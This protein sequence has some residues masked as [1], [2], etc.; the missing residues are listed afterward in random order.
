MYT[1]VKKSAPA[2]ME[3]YCKETVRAEMYVTLLFSTVL[4]DATVLVQVVRGECHPMSSDIGDLTDVSRRR[5]TP[6]VEDIVSKVEA[7]YPIENGESS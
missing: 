6:I 4:I 3:S 1:K 2:D 5:R 7:I